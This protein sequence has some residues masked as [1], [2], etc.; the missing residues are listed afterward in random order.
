MSGP[1]DVEIEDV[2]RIEV[3][4]TEGR[5]FVT[6]VEPGV[7]MSVQ[8]DGRTIKLFVGRKLTE[9]ETIERWKP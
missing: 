6:Y 4:G 8:D 2:E 9:D 3:I 1:H 5:E 7:T